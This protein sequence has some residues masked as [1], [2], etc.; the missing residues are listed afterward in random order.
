[1]SCLADQHGREVCRWVLF[2]TA[3]SLICE[4]GNIAS[5]F[6]F[7]RNEISWQQWLKDHSAR[8]TDRMAMLILSLVATTC[9]IVLTII[10]HGDVTNGLKNTWRGVRKFSEVASSINPSRLHH[11]MFNTSVHPTDKDVDPVQEDE[12]PSDG[13]HG[14][15]STA[16]PLSM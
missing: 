1:M 8:S 3:M 7:L 5:T 12:A 10:G 14:L 16:A 11:R 2:G 15:E 4:L 13:L 6:I 9:V